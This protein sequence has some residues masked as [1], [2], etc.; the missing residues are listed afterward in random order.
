MIGMLTFIN[1][2]RRAKTTRVRRRRKGAT[3]REGKEK[4]MARKT[5][6][7]RR[8]RRSRRRSTPTIHRRRRRRVTVSNPAPVR[9]RR[10]R[11]RKNPLFRS[12]RTGKFKGSAPGKRLHRRR[13]RPH[14]WHNPKRRRSG[15][16]YRRNPGTGRRRIA[17]LSNP[18]NAVMQVVKE[19]FSGDTLEQVFQT[20]LGFGAA[21]AGQRFVTRKLFPG[22]N[23]DVGRV[24]VTFGVSLIETLLL[25]FFGQSR[26]AV[27]ALTGG[28]LATAWQ[29][30]SEWLPASVKDFVPT[31]G[32]NEDAE[33]RQAIEQEVLRE[34]RG[35]SSDEGMS[36]YL[37]PAGVSDT[38]L[39]PAGSS[40]YLTQS[41]AD[42]AA[43]MSV[44]LTR[45]EVEATSGMGDSDGEFGRG[46]M[47]ERF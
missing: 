34:I 43:G 37:T 20:G 45:K 25:S 14:Y 12:R 38:Y 21:A 30:A 36:V 23:T 15:R 22:L 28:L 17:L 42:R 33:F 26:M 13:R 24:G 2:P 3:A 1:P 47:P 18:V 6:V 32:D 7:R 16:R 29:G 35:G 9:R 41:E 39:Q 44:Y 19:A 46:G 31:L 11:S 27:R 40:A 4:V 8:V 10:R 5:R